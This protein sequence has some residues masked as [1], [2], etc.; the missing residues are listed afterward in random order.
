MVL[1]GVNWVHNDKIGSYGLERSHLSTQCKYQVIW[2][3]KSQLGTQY[4]KYRAYLLRQVVFCFTEK[5]MDFSVWCPVEDWV[6]NVFF[7][8]S[9]LKSACKHFQTKIHSFHQNPQFSSKSIDFHQKPWISIK[10][11]GFHQ[12][13]QFLAFLWAFKRTTSNRYSMWNERLERYPLYL[14]YCA[15]CE[16]FNP[17]WKMILWSGCPDRSPVEYTMESV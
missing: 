7:A 17:V 11:C 5:S 9:E 6:G 8:V 3:W 12:N 10:I 4:K 16:N 1:K 13:P 14:E 15:I 2:S